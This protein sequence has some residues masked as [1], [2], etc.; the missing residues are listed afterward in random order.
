MEAGAGRL[1]AVTA[2]RPARRPL[3][4]YL[5]STRGRRGPGS[6]TRRAAWAGAGRGEA[7]LWVQRTPESRVPT[8]PRRSNS[9]GRSSGKRWADSRSSRSR[10]GLGWCKA[11][12][13]AAAP[14]PPSTEATPLH[15]TSSPAG[16][17]ALCSRVES[18]VSLLR[19]RRVPN[20]E[21]KEPQQNKSHVL[22]RPI[23][24]PEQTT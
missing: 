13:P 1:R 7:W 23:C 18:L 19:E 12:P 14:S 24:F 4:P 9:G 6:D 5:S 8:G 16:T 10:K 20:N 17:L 3:P 22:K 15:L 11:S 21:V 2:P